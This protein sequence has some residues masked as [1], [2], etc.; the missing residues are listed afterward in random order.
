[1]QSHRTIRRPKAAAAVLSASVLALF[2]V[3]MSPLPQ[4]LASTN[5]G[6]PSAALNSVQVAIQPKNISSAS[7]YDL[8]VYNS[9]GIPVA[10]YNGQFPMITFSLP[11][12]T[13]LFSATVSGQASKMPA[14]CVCAESG[15]VAGTGV[16]SPPTQSTGTGAA[17]SAIAY[18]CFYSGPVEYGYSLTTVSGSTSITIATQPP[19]SIPTTGVNVSVSYK[20][21]TAAAGAYVY[22]SMVGYGWYYGA[23]SNVVLD[24]QTGANGVA[25]LVVPEAPLIVSASKSIPVVL[26]K[27]ETTTQVKVG[28]E[29][30]NVTLYYSPYYIYE[31]TTGLLIPPQTSLSMVLSANVSYPPIPYGVASASGAAT[32]GTATVGTATASLNGSQTL[33]PLGA[34]AG[35]P[36]NS[37]AQTTSQIAPIPPITTGGAGVALTSSTQSASQASAPQAGVNIAEIGTIALAGA[38]AATAGV[39]ISRARH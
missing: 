4:L 12:G 30:V 38:L 20:N 33:P 21:G 1:M 32:P 5:G 3:S 28:G 23:N 35:S 2:L 26:P 9:T 34:A 10:S 8:V 29:L 25:H 31:S 14:C 11:S 7:S 18:P 36:T 39:M 22:A 15:T 17:S 13:Y 27:G 16:A 6:V 19:S 37:P 24:A